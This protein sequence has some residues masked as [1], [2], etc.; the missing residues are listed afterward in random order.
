MALIKG[1]NEFV[2]EIIAYN[3][4]FSIYGFGMVAQKLLSVL[5]EKIVT[6][7]DRNYDKFQANRYYEKIQPNKIEN[8]TTSKAIL[9]CIDPFRN[10]KKR[11][12]EIV[13]SYSELDDSFTFYLLDDLFIKEKGYIDLNDEVLLVDNLLFI[14]NSSYQYDYMK[15][16]YGMVPKFSKE[17]LQKLY[18]EPVEYEYKKGKIGL[19]DF[20][21]GLI[22]HENG[23][24]ICEQFGQTNPRH[25]IWL[26]GDSRVSGM[27]I[28]NEYTIASLLG[29]KMKDSDYGIVNCGIPGREI[30]RMMYQIKT[31]E[32]QTDDIVILA[33]G[34]YEY[35]ES[36]LRNLG[37]WVE[38][39]K[40]C[41]EI[42]REKQAEFIYV[43]MPTDFRSLSV[44]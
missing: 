7:Y 2:E 22:I 36:Y 31:E 38:T 39:I 17:Y 16:A 43:S 42:C 9:I 35:G 8:I 29:R 12:K 34:F 3:K 21:N 25:N 28:P 11:A 30:E 32:I 15:K 6:I 10:Y 20:N 18:D 13:Y 23:K 14:V 44:E 4:T 19:P 40:A 27:L 24:K 37:C 41:Q 1:W 5:N 26:F 33:T